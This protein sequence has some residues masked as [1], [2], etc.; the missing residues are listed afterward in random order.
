MA[1]VRAEFVARGPGVS[2]Y[3]PTVTVHG[4]MYH[5]MEALLPPTGMKPRFAAVY[6]HDTEQAALLRKYFYSVPHEKLVGKLASMLNE[7]YNLV[8]TFISLRDLI[9]RDCIPEEVQIVIHA[10]E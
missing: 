6:I 1:S 10:H 2:K 4:R 8:R 7:N 9:Q 3:N 5:E